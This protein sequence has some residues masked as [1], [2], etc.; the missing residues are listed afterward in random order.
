[1]VNDLAQVKVNLANV[2]KSSYSLAKIGIANQVRQGDPVCALGSPLCDHMNTLTAGVI[3]NVNRMDYEIG[4]KKKGRR[5][6]QT[7]C[8]INNGN[9]GG[10]LVNLNGEVIGVVVKLVLSKDY[11]KTRSEGIAFVIPIDTV[12]NP[13]IMEGNISQDGSAG[14]VGKEKAP[15]AVL[16]VPLDPGAT[17]EDVRKR[18]RAVRKKILLEEAKQQKQLSKLEKWR[19]ELKDL[20]E[21]SAQI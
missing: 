8:A 11:G 3:S 21:K 2:D 16:G 9:S 14:F 13:V 19:Q 5:F 1:M 17:L 6:F 4:L 10:P 15:G 7:D 20:K 12:L 18:I